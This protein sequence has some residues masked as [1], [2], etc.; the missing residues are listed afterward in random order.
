MIVSINFTDPQGRRTYDTIHVV[1]LGDVRILQRTTVLEDHGA[2][3]DSVDVLQT[4][5]NVREHDANGRFLQ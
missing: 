2:T 4:S 3:I 5:D 1:D